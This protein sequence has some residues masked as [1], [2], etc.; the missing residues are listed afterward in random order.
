M[1]LGD[2]MKRIVFHI[3]VNN[4]FL[5]WTAVLLLNQGYRYDIRTS[6]AVIGGDEKAR[7]GIVLAKSMAAKKMGIYTSETLYSARK[8][9]PALRIYPPNYLW[10]QKQSNRLFELL[11]TYTNEIE[12]FSIDECFLN[13]GAIEHLYGDAYSFALKLKD[14]IEQ[15]LGFTVNIGIANNKLCAKMASDFEKPNKVHTLYQEEVETKM[16]PLPIGDLFG[17]GK[18]SVEK[19]KQLGIH[20]IG[21]LAHSEANHLFPYFKNQS[22]HLIELANGI[23]ESPIQAIPEE[24]KGISNS[25]TLSHDVTNKSEVF[26]ILESLSDNVGLTL[27]RQEKY[28]SVIAITM[29]DRYFKSSSHQRKLKNATNLTS[30]IFEVTR[31]LFEESWNSEPLRLLGVSLMGLSNKSNHQVSLFDSLE[32]RDQEMKLETTVDELK[33]KYGLDVIGSAS[34]KEKK[35]GKK[36]LK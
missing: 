7:R 25:T 3:D 28:A 31:E 35:V 9:C 14:Q 23:D 15:T 33:E 13:Y 4:A 24:N 2:H 12:V 5:S 32:K 34:L 6:Y 20:T 36:Y 18:R 21:D 26:R 19:L 27:R 29:K 30:E 22:L 16:W 1:R 10:Y 8:K 11:S 17:V